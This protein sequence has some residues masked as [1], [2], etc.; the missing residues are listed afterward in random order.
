M[1]VI[2]DGGSNMPTQDLYHLS[3]TLGWEIIQSRPPIVALATALSCVLAA[4]ILASRGLWE[5]VGALVAVA[6]LLG[7]WQRHITWRAP[8]LVIQGQ[9]VTHYREGEDARSY[10]LSD[11]SIVEGNLTTGCAFF[12]TGF[13]GTALGAVGL[14]RNLETSMSL[15]GSP[16]ERIILIMSGLWLAGTAFSIS[17]I[18]FPRRKLVLGIAPYR[19]RAIYI[20]DRKQRERMLVLR[21]ARHLEQVMFRVGLGPDAI[22]AAPKNTNSL[23][24]REEGPPQ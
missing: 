21:R 18:D 11:L 22:T 5:W 4:C 24:I 14:S 10:K 16:A 2:N 6:G 3:H 7:I 17:W 20:D 19:P 13:V 23:R 1:K 15:S 12:A 9:T 8:I